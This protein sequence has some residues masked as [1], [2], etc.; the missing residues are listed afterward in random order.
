[1]ESAM[2]AKDVV[3]AEKNEKKELRV[4]AREGAKLLLAIE[5]A[6]EAARAAGKADLE[7]LKTMDGVLPYVFERLSANDYGSPEDI[8]HELDDDRLI[9]LV[10]FSAGK[11]RQLRFNA[12]VAMNTLTGGLVPVTYKALSE[13]EARDAQAY[14]AA[15]V[16]PAAAAEAT[17]AEA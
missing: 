16:A 12:A 14:D 8:F 4:V 11:A 15:A 9:N 2:G 7:R 3:K 17:A 13:P 5:R 1:M 6:A 10:G